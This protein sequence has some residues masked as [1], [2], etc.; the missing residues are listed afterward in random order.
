MV[1]V[2][3]LDFSYDKQREFIKGM[4][5]DVHQGEIFGFLGPSGAGKSTL[6]KILS[7]ILRSYSGSVRVL[8]TEVKNRKDSFYEDIGVDFEFPN[9][10][11]KFTGLENLLFFASLYG[12]KSTNPMEYLERVGLANDAHKKVASYSKGM[13]MR[14]AFVRAIIHQPSLLFLDEPTSGLDPSFSR[15]LKDMI[16]EQKKEGKTIILTTHNM[17]DAEE[18]CDRVA[19]IVDGQIKAL[20]RPHAL[21]TRKSG[22][23]VSYTYKEEGQEKAGM[24]ELSSLYQDSAFMMRL[25]AGTLTG[26]HSKEPTLEDVFI[27]LTGRC[28]Q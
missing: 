11:G 22:V 25:K 17:H 2:R 9:L 13:K 6:Q 5:I 27:E 28:L 20:D 19:F 7:G 14:L 15:I 8:N 23:E 4:S 18:L 16:L 26:V 1:T 10:Y 3:Q 24:A 12:R 21:R